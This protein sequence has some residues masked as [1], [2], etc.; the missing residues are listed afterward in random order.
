M[1]ANS[2]Q[3]C[4]LG[5]CLSFPTVIKKLPWSLVSFAESK[6]HS[7]TCAGHLLGQGLPHPTSSLWQHCAH[8]H[9]LGISAATSLPPPTHSLVHGTI[10][11]VNIYG[12]FTLCRKLKYPHL[13]L[14]ATTLW[15]STA[16]TRTA[17]GIGTL[18]SHAL[19]ADFEAKPS[20]SSIK[21]TL[22]CCVSPGSW[23]QG[24]HRAKTQ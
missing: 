4:W 15:L 23:A 22:L 8:H 1:P 7:L 6:V 13:F 17:G 3:Y 16:A 14:D 2:N 18:P 9:H 19:F 5:L 21:V 12:A 11:S 20:H 10:H 24:G